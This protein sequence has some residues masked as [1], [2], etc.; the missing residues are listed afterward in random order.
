[1]TIMPVAAAVSIPYEA[2][3]AFCEK[4]HITKM[5]LFGSVLRADFRADSDIDVLVE[6][7][8]AHVPGWEIVA[9]QDELAALFGR[10]VDLGT[11]NGLREWLKPHVMAAS[12]VIYERA[13]QR[14][15]D[16]L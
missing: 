6:F 14:D 15:A 11:P 12:Q 8:P 16:R 4:H 9:M 1:M 2:L 7:D 13:V 10:S 5:W 3:A